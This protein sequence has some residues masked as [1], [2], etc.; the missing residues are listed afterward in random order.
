MDRRDRDMACA[1]CV[2]VG[3]GAGVGLRAGGANPPPLAAARVLLRDAG[4]GAMAMPQPAGLEATDLAPWQVGHVDVEDRVGRQRI[5]AQ[6][7]DDGNRRARRGLEMQAFVVGGRQRHR[8]CR[9]TEEAAF[10]RRRHSAGINHVVAQVGGIV[11]AGHHDVRFQLQHAGDRHVHAVGRGAVN[12][13][14]L[15]IQLHHADRCIQG[16]RIAGA[17]A[18]AVGGDHQDLVAGL[19]QPGR[20]GTDAGGVDAVVVAD[21]YPHGA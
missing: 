19:A 18:V 16:Q 11:D 15:R 2:E 1:H 13:P 4:F 21:Q 5:A 9:Q 17:A 10:H 3:A 7:G 8:H 12:L 20:K 6:A 14:G